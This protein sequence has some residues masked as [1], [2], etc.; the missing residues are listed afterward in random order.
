MGYRGGK[1]CALEDC[2]TIT[3][4]DVARSMWPAAF[5]DVVEQIRASKSVVAKDALA[6]FRWALRRSP[7]TP[8]KAPNTS[9]AVVLYLDIPSI[10]LVAERGRLRRISKLYSKGKVVPGNW[11]F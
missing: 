2:G 7:T 10:R 3:P 1:M 11:S 9:P 8:K 6:T 4:C 5:E